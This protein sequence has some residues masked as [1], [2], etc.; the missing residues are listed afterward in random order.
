LSERTE[1]LLD[2]LRILDRQRRAMGDVE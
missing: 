1:G 2:L